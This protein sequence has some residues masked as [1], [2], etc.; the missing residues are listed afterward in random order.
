MKTTELGKQ[1][2]KNGMVGFRWVPK[3]EPTV[4]GQRREK[5]VFLVGRLVRV[6]FI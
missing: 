5:K 6:E 4:D 2:Q 3:D 1:S